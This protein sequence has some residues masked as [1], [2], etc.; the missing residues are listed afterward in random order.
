MKR[1]IIAIIALF[2]IVNCGTP[3]EHVLEGKI[4]TLGLSQNQYLYL[5]KLENQ[6]YIP[7]DSTVVGEEGK[8]SLDIME[9]KNGIY[10]FGSSLRNTIPI[11]LNEEA[12]K[13]EITI[14]NNQQVSLDY[15]V[16]GSQASEQIALFSGEV[17]KMMMLNQKLRQNA[18]NIDPTNFAAQQELQNEF[19]VASK[20][21][22]EFRDQFIADNKGSE[23]LIAVIQQINPEEEMDLFKEVVNDLN[24]TMPNTSYAKDLNDYLSKKEAEAAK[25][26]EM[27]KLTEIGM[28]APELDFP[29]IDGTNVKLSSLRGKVVLIDFWA[30]WCKPC[31]AENPNVVRAYQKY[32]SKGFEVFSFSLDKNKA[33]WISAIEQDGLVWNSHASDLKQWQTAALPLYGFRGIPFTVLIDREGKI[34]AKNLRGPALEAKLNEVL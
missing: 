5:Y 23:A 32:K 14:N 28:M 34:I 15:D 4:D 9:A 12:K 30:S 25:A 8:F 26:K 16:K 13:L 2:A 24:K 22:L 29:G 19:G 6:Q 20:K 27:S 18:E 33:Q 1:I 11:V 31:R 3:P 21:F 17:Y 10:H 7:I